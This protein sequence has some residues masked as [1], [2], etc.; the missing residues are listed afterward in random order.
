MNDYAL[1]YYDDICKA[2]RLAMI[3]ATDYAD[4]RGHTVNPYIRGMN[5]LMDEIAK[6][7][8]SKEERREKTTEDGNA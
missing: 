3:K 1:I 6:M 5:I 7:I 8:E 4:E 2:Q